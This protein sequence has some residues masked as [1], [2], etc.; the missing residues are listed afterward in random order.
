MAMMDLLTV[1]GLDS[2]SRLKNARDESMLNSEKGRSRQ[3]MARRVATAR[4]IADV[5]EDWQRRK[6]FREE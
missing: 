1:P 3:M 6:D 5:A 4:R 2:R